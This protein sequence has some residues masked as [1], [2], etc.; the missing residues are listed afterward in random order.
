MLDEDQGSTFLCLESG[1]LLTDAVVGVLF[2]EGE[3]S[4]S[5]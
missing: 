4:N 1:I 3:I 2:R 5:P